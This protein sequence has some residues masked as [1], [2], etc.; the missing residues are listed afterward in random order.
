MDMFSLIVVFEAILV[1]LI[2]SIFAGK[3]HG[4]Y[5]SKLK[6]E[7]RK[8][9]FNLWVPIVLALALTLLVQGVAELF[10]YPKWLY[11]IIVGILYI[12]YVISFVYFAKLKKQ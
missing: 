3:F 4:M 10:P 11:Y 1:G 8:E 2:F 7:D 5:A 6:A 9:L 12:T